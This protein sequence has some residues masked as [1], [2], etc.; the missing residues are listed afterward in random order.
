[1]RDVLKLLSA[2]RSFCLNL[3]PDKIYVPN[4]DKPGYLLLEEEVLKEY[5]KLDVYENA[6]NCIIK[7]QI[8]LSDSAIYLDILNVILEYSNITAVLKSKYGEYNEYYRHTFTH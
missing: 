1:M 3:N 8:L 4:K 6:I 7:N 2:M 5:S